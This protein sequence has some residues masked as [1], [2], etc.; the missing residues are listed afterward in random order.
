MVSV[1]RAGLNSLISVD[2]L[3]SPCSVRMAHHR[4]QRTGVA[5]WVQSPSRPGAPK[6]DD[7]SDLS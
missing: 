4:P 3:L 7:E 6:E 1:K 5:M 2:R